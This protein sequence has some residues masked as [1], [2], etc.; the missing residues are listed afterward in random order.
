VF[1]AEA[2]YSNT[3]ESGRLGSGSSCSRRASQQLQRWRSVISEVFRVFQ[4]SLRTSQAPGGYCEPAWRI[5]HKAE[6]NA[7]GR[8][9]GL[10][11]I[12]KKPFD[13]F[14]IGAL[15]I[16]LCA[17]PSTHA[18]MPAQPAHPSQPAQNTSAPQA[19]PA[20]G[21]YKIDPD[22]S[23]AFFGARH[24]VV[25]LVRG[26]F[27]KVMGTIIVSPDLAACSVDV[28]V[29]VSSISTQNSVR[30]ADLRSPAYFDVNKFPAMTYTGRGIRRVSG[31]SWTMDGSLTMHG[32]TKVVPL[33]FTFNGSFS[34]IKPG[35]PARVA[36][37]GS[38]GVKRA[39]F[40]MG[41]RDNLMELG[42]LTTPDVEIEID[43]EADST[44]PSQ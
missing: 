3:I 22:H 8:R 2:D 31:D 24:H 39:D 10:N 14:A 34:D 11:M 1:H 23:F 33:T 19:L 32:V 4:A 36:F 25:G 20:P 43:V 6:V 28:T 37:H 5:A 26:R 38:A 18:A 12:L 27:D 35:K 17:T 44:A 9:K 29:D 16:S 15:L 13:L 7:M 41:S 21:T 42:I 30:D 40:G